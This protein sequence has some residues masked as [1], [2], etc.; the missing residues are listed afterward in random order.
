MAVSADS[1]RARRKSEVIDAAA[2]CFMARGYH[3]TSIDDVAA[4]LGCSKGRI[5]HHYPSKFA[6]F[7]AVHREGMERLF[8]ARDAAMSTRGTALVRLEAMLLAHAEAM[9]RH[10]TYETVVAQGVQLHRFDT[11][12]EADRAE[13]AALIALRNRFEDGYKQVITAGLNDGSIRTEN[14]SVTA[15]TLLGALQWSIYWYRPRDGESDEER[16]TLAR[17]M[18]DPL[19]NGLRPIG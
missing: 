12:S 2:E 1:P 4:H 7:S 18:V 6:L 5:Y 9:L 3:T 13:L 19:I 17:Q 16:S 11:G 10:I 8:S 14:Q 15:K